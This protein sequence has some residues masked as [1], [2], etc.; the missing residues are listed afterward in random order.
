M[1]ELAVIEIL[2][3]LIVASET[4]YDIFEAVNFLLRNVQK[5]LPH[6]RKNSRA[7]DLVYPYPRNLSMYGVTGYDFTDDFGYRFGSLKC[8]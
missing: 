5:R 1:I 7:L 8:L 6:S 2:M 3:I 4:L